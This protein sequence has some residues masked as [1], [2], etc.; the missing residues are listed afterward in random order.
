MASGEPRP[1]SGHGDEI[2]RL[3]PPLPSGHQLVEISHDG[4]EDFEVAGVDRTG[5][6]LGEVVDT[7]GATEGSVV[8]VDP[9]SFAALTVEADGQWTLTFLPLT[10]AQP[11]G[12]GNA[13]S[14]DHSQVLYLPEPLGEEIP[15]IG[16]AHV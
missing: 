8:V 3:D 10:S 14:G 5:E 12:K 1:F 6:E 7:S 13:W 9:E 16:R 15:K 4:S 11:F 2:I